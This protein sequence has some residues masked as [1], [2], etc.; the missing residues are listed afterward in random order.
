VQPDEVYNL[1]AISFV[2]LSFKQAELT[3]EVTGLGVL[4]MLEAVRMVGGTENNPIRFYQ[5]SSSEMFGK[6]REV[7]QS[8]MTP[9]YPRSPYGVSKVYGHY[10]TVNYRESY[11]MFA[12]SGI[13]FNHESPRRGL[14][15][16][17][18]KVTDGV[19]RIK[20]GLAE[21]LSLGNLDAKRDWGFAGDYVKAMWMMLQ[22]EHAEDYVIATGVSHSVRDLVEVSF[23]HVG[24]DWQKHVRLDPKLIRPAEVE[25]LIGDSSK[26]RTELGWKPSVDFAKLIKMM[27]DADLE[28]LA[29][30][31]LLAD[32][33]FTL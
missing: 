15:F 32:R 13:L 21:T 9:F 14:E 19:A 26:A 8:E 4:R 29:T 11:G 20:L 24:L 5:A 7:P 27:V 22:Q 12:V 2:Q 6:V 16:V 3:A 17:T 18:R 10:I 25:H 23:G 31:P 28:R 33:L 30:A 1:G